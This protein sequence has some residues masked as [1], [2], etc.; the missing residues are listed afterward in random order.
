MQLN[1][2][3]W[4]IGYEERVDF[5][6][7]SAELHGLQSTKQPNRQQESLHSEWKEK[8]RRSGSSEIRQRVNTGVP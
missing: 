2:C 1:A 4:F 8:L 7:Q 5:R 6:G 3:L